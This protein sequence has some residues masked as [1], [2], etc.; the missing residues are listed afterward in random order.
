M[1]WWWDPIRF[2]LCWLPCCLHI[3]VSIG[4]LGLGDT[5]RFNLIQNSHLVQKERINLGVGK[6]DRT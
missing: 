2:N 3:D 4:A 6:K 5:S 1:P